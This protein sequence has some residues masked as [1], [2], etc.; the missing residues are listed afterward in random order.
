MPPEASQTTDR[1]K[2]T[3]SSETTGNLG[4]LVVPSDKFWSGISNQQRIVLLQE[5]DARYQQQL[6]ELYAAANLCVE[7]YEGLSSG[8]MYWRRLVIVGTSVVAL[9]NLF[10][11]NR[12]LAI[13]APNLVP[14]IAAVIAVVLALLANLESFLNYSERAQA[15][16]E[17]RDLF[18]DAARDYDR[19]WDIYVRPFG[20]E[21]EACLNATELY[22]RIVISDKDLRGKFKELT[23]TE[24]KTG[25]T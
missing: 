10:A 1:P 24:K 20:S 6:D 13:K 22:R 4:G 8:H 3:P 19:L 2:T 21:P 7:R 25:K 11:A 18:L 9:A 16:R 23:K 17:S 14:M 12:S 5:F 15:Y